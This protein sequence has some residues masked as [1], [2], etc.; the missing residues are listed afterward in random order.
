VFSPLQERM[1]GSDITVLRGTW[2]KI[3]QIYLRK[4][5]EVIPTDSEFPLSPSNAAVLLKQ[6]LL[7]SQTEASMND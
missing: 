1:T 3:L 7:F 4:C 5:L 2:R 6:R